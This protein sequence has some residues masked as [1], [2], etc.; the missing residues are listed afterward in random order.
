[1]LVLT[2]KV[3]EKLILYT[4][5]GH[6]IEVEPVEIRGDQVRIGITADPDVII[7]REEVVEDKFEG[8]ISLV[9]DEGSKICELPR[10]SGLTISEAASYGAGRAGMDHPDQVT[11]H[12]TYDTVRQ[13]ALH[14]AKTLMLRP[15]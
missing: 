14:G 12:T 9:D 6:R 11:I 1:M 8:T 15:A 5:D 13:A 2:R 10:D 7:D 3:D 4:P